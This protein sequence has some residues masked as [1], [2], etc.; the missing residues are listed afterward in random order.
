M[1]TGGA[2]R[3]ACMRHVA[4]RWQQDA[5]LASQAADCQASRRPAPQRHREA[6]VCAPMC[7]CA[8]HPLGRAQS[9]LAGAPRAVCLAAALRQPR[10]AQP[11]Q[12]RWCPT[13]ARLN[14]RMGQDSGKDAACSCVAKATCAGVPPR[15]HRM[16]LW[17]QAGAPGGYARPASAGRAPPAMSACS[18]SSRSAA[19]CAAAS[20]CDCGRR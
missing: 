13:S 20:S 4:S 18:A 17:P 6:R 3:A 14:G 16:R 8:P 11:A 12:R 5:L 1:C 2:A 9:L 19:A 15:R 7:G 10:T